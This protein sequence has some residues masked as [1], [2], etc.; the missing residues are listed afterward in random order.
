MARKHS[1]LFASCSVLILASTSLAAADETPATALVCTGS[2]EWVCPADPV[3]WC[4][5][6]EFFGCHPV[7]TGG[8]QGVWVACAPL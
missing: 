4:S 3:A 2:H 5:P 8:G 7:G 1:L 6:C